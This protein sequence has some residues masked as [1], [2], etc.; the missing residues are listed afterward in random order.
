MSIRVYTFCATAVT[1]SAVAGLLVGGYLATTAEQPSTRH[2]EVTHV[3]EVGP[4]EATL[5]PR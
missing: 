2:A 1:V 4:A 3:T 5:P